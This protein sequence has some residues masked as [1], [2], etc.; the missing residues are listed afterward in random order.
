MET[1]V[2]VSSL[3]LRWFSAVRRRQC[4]SS[5]D[6]C[7]LSKKTHCREQ[8]RGFTISTPSGAVSEQA[9]STQL[10]RAGNA[11]GAA[12]ECPC[13]YRLSVSCH[14]ERGCLGEAIV[15][16]VEPQR[17]SIISMGLQ[18]RD[19]QRPG[20]P[21]LVTKLKALAFLGSCYLSR[22]DCS[23]SGPGICGLCYTAPEHWLCRTEL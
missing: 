13:L 5:R 1:R 2:S 8:D 23:G 10:E 12:A 19:Q 11:H 15:K 3:F 20:R 14:P 21:A 4:G 22:T 6:K 9:C 16:G 17:S 18:G 7:F